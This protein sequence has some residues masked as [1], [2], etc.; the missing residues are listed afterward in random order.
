MYTICSQKSL[1]LKPTPHSLQGDAN[2]LRFLI[3][4]FSALH[5]PAGSIYARLIQ[6]QNHYTLLIEQI[7]KIL[8]SFIIDTFDYLGLTR[9]V[10]LL[11]CFHDVSHIYRLQTVVFEESDW[12]NHTHDKFMLYCRME[13]ERLKYRHRCSVYRRNNRRGDGNELGM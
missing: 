3:L 7:F 6:P 11:Q 13:I 12:V 2:C 5:C 10:K 9:A 4:S 8:F 1:N